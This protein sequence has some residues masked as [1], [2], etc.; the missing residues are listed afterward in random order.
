MGLLV[1]SLSTLPGW[2]VSIWRWAKGGLFSTIALYRIR[3]FDSVS[4]FLFLKSKP[5]LIIEHLA[6]SFP[7]L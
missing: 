6:V 3:A 1:H 4:S 7:L 5:M 2:H